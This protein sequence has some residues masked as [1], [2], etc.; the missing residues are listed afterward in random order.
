[1]PSLPSVLKRAKYNAEILVKMIGAA[2]AWMIRALWSP[3]AAIPSP[4]VTAQSAHP[5]IAWA[6]IITL[7]RRVEWLNADSLRRGG[8]LSIRSL[9]VSW[10]HNH[11]IAWPVFAERSD[12]FSCFACI[13]KSADHYSL[14]VWQR[15]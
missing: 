7:C 12:P 2:T 9:L 13:R 15:A 6:A 1:M 11:V 14:A 5:T 10:W 8:S 3:A 4:M